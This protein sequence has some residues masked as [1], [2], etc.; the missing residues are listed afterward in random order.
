VASA[1]LTGGPAVASPAEALPAE[2][3]R[4]WLIVVG[5]AGLVLTASGLAAHAL[6]AQPT[7]TK[8]L[9]TVAGPLLLLG[10]ALSRDP[11]RAPMT[12]VIV[13]VPFISYQATFGN[14]T[15]SAL[16]A[17]L[18]LAAVL[19]TV[20]TSTTPLV[21]TRTLVVLALLVV[22]VALASDP[23][24]QIQLIGLVAL[25]IWLVR[26]TAAGEEGLLFVLGALV[27]CCALQGALGI[28]QYET[29]QQFSL[30]TGTTSGF[31]SDYFFSY[32]DVNRPTAAFFDPISFGNILALGIPV[33]IALAV[34]LRQVGLRLAAAGA[35]AIMALALIL[36]LSRMSWVGAAAGALVTIALLPGRLRLV[37]LVGTAA[38]V[39]VTVSV[40]V[41]AEG[42][43]LIE[44]AQSLSDPTSASVSTGDTDRGRVRIWDASLDVFRANPI[45]GV[46]LGDL[47]EELVGRVGFGSGVNGHAHSVY[48]QTLATAGV[49]GALALL[50]L[51]F[52]AVRRTLGALRAPLH[53]RPDAHRGIMATGIGGGLVA[54]A[55]V[56]ATDTTPRYEQVSGVIAVLLGCALALGRR[57]GPA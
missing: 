4:L 21:T 30:L 3:W 56:C 47:G 28:W 9:A 31:G 18:L 42:T 1:G 27:A 14:V 17:P 57:P 48:L 45:A 44:R 16:V 29:G 38:V 22:P 6:F 19:A 43:D 53:T 34:G 5:L 23:A 41:G 37:A 11:L 35:A 8:Q 50:L 55:I 33:A 7:L 2:R 13:G 15:A 20:A 49:L 24:A 46:G 52:E 25:V 10:C 26:R 40:A 32:G 54:L 51:A 12:L 36:T 39:A